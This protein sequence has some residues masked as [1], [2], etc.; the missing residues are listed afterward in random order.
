MDRNSPSA[1]AGLG[2][3][4]RVLRRGSDP[5]SEPESLP[6]ALG[7]GG[8]P[9]AECREKKTWKGYEAAGLT[10]EPVTRRVPGE[11]EKKQK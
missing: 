7:N 5:K 8:T 9:N 10:Q 11:D 6:S 1:L 4:S 2:S 3:M